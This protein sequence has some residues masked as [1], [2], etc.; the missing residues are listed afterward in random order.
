[1]STPPIDVNHALLDGRY[2]LIRALGRGSFG[3]TFSRG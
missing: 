2:E 1:V 3:Q